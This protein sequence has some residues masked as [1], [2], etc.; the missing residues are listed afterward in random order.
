VNGTTK[1]FWIRL[2]IVAAGALQGTSVTSPETVAISNVDWTACV[3]LLLGCPILLLIIV[4]FHAFNP[5]S[6]PVWRR[7]AWH[8]NPFLLGEPLQFFHLA[9]FSVM[10]GGVLGVAT[11]P[12]R[13]VSAAPL[14]VSLL[15]IGIGLWLGIHLC[16]KVC[17][18][19]M[20]PG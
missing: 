5:A 13:G 20:E 12:S 8:I 3:V 15:C 6:T 1:W 10:A 14:A 11:L 19:K 16:M 2:A 9:A 17:R 4:S 7:P 18:K